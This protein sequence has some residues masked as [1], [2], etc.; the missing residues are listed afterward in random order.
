MS[1]IPEA[2]R[3]GYDMHWCTGGHWVGARG[4]VEIG[5]KCTAPG[6]LGAYGPFVYSDEEWIAFDGTDKE[7]HEIVQERLCLQREHTA[8]SQAI[9]VP[10]A[11]TLKRL[12]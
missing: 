8:R 12:S 7:W 11:E 5:T 4:G 10:V 2:L 6:C 3:R 9:T 1:E